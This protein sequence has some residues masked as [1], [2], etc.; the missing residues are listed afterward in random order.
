MP[1]FAKKRKLVVKRKKH[2]P[3][4]ALL[5]VSAKSIKFTLKTKIYS[6]LK[7]KSKFPNF[8]KIKR[9]TVLGMMKENRNFIRDLET[10]VLEETGTL[11]RQVSEMRLRENITAYG[12]AG[13]FKA[14]AVSLKEE[15]KLLSRFLGIDKIKNQQIRKARLTEFSIQANKFYKEYSAGL[16]LISKLNSLSNIKNPVKRKAEYEKLMK[17]FKNSNKSQDIPARLGK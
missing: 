14:L 8:F 1:S 13:A 3:V 7:I 2:K 4:K 15:I 16:K 17:E 12:F 11:N 9:K 6:L 10:L 5:R